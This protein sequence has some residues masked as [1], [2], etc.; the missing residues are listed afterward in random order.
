MYTT[1]S[2][3]YPIGGMF[4]I[5]VYTRPK[6]LS[7]RRRRHAGYSWFK[8]FVMVVRAGGVVP[9]VVVED[10]Q[11]PDEV[12]P[13]SNPGPSSMILTSGMILNNRSEAE[14]DRIYYKDCQFQ[15]PPPPSTDRIYYKDCQFPIPP[16]PSTEEQEAQIGQVSLSTS[17]K[18]IREGD[19]MDGELGFR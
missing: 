4:N 5:L 6:V 17:L 1:T 11:Q 2:I 15:I 19:D 18:I 3:I 14:V 9:M 7:L 10:D 13:R 12:Y 16:P 8:A